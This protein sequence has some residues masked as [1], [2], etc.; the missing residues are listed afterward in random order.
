MRDTVDAHRVLLLESLT[1][2]T[3]SLS[4]PSRVTG[5][6][7]L[8]RDHS[9]RADAEE[10][11]AGAAEARAEAAEAEVPQAG[12][13]AAAAAARATRSAERHVHEEHRH[14]MHAAG[15]RTARAVRDAILMSQAAQLYLALRGVRTRI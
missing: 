10:E 12:G 5:G 7:A 2:R 8:G 9:W 6:V 15:A 14:A 3:A 11:R 4:E 13:G 1:T